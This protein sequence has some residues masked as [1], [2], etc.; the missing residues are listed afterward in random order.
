MDENFV[1]QENQQLAFE[2]Y[3]KTIPA[4][5]FEKKANQTISLGLS[6]QISTLG[7]AIKKLSEHVDTCKPGRVTQAV[8]SS[9]GKFQH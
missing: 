5:E 7:E 4:Y 6:N 8:K 3:Q 9:R 2:S 1:V